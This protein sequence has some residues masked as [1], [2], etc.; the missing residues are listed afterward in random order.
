MRRKYRCFGCGKVTEKDEK[1]FDNIIELYH[2]FEKKKQLQQ[3]ENIAE[4]SGIPIEKIQQEV[5]C[6]V[7]SSVLWDKL[8]TRFKKIKTYIKNKFIQVW[9]I[10]TTFVSILVARIYLWWINTSIDRKVV[11]YRFSTF[12][13]I[14]IGIFLTDFFFHCGFDK[15]AIFVLILYGISKWR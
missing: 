9:D 8:P 15:A 6:P 14:L 12:A 1:Y 11:Y 7:C 2:E 13:G 4:I 10:F 3:N 5:K